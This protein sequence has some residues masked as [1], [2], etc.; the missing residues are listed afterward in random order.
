MGLVRQMEFAGGY[1]CS[2][3]DLKLDS[4]DQLMK[5]MVVEHPDAPRL[6]C[7]LCSIEEETPEQLKW[8]YV[9][10]HFLDCPFVCCLFCP[11]LFCSKVL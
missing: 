1:P 8:H 5:H 7:S 6:L 9:K 4:F 2:A 10:M 11:R 3:C